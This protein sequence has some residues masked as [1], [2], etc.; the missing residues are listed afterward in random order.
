MMNAVVFFKYL[1][2][3]PFTKWLHRQDAA[4]IARLAR[5]FERFAQGNLG[6]YKML[7]P[8]LYEARLFYAGGLRI[9]FTIQ[10]GQLI[11]ILCGGDKKTQSK[12]IARAKKYLAIIQG[13]SY[14][15]EK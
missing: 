10:N 14:D 13:G 15:P 5:L 8:Y 9:Y 7:A 4:V 6:D 11:I 2:K 3:S 1:G 12:D